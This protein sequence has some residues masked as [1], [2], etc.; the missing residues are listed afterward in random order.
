M[1]FVYANEA[2]LLNVAL[3][4]MTAKEWRDANPDKKGNIR[5][6]AV[7]EQLV[8]LSNMESINALLI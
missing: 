8:V 1:S 7:I 5:D 4:G 6:Y 2:D 3:F